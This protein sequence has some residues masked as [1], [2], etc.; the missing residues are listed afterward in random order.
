VQK[1]NKGQQVTLK[2]QDTLSDEQAV[3]NGRSELGMEVENHLAWGN[4]VE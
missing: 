1:D 3:Q 4:R 2:F